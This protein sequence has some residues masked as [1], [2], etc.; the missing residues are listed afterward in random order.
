MWILVALLEVLFAYLFWL[1]ASKPEF[2]ISAICI[3]RSKWTP[4]IKYTLLLLIRYKLIWNLDYSQLLH[5]IIS[6]RVLGRRRNINNQDKPIRHFVCRSGPCETQS[7]P[8]LRYHVS[9][10]VWLSATASVKTLPEF[11]GRR[12]SPYGLKTQRPLDRFYKIL[13]FF[14]NFCHPEPQQVPAF[15]LKL[16]CSLIVSVMSA[17]ESYLLPRRGF[18]YFC[19]CT[20]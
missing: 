5:I 4:P 12:M 14:Y 11:K 8:D 17:L 13:I 18:D 6:F 3:T 15:W 10:S 20:Q 2:L 1:E 7:F 9:N 16:F 19:L